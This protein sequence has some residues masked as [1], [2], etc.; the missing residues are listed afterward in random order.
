MLMHLGSDIELTVAYA[1]AAVQNTCSTD[2]ETVATMRDQGQA[3]PTTSAAFATIAF[4]RRYQFQFLFA[5]CCLAGLLDLLQ[6]FTSSA[7]HPLV[8]QY[9]SGC[10]TNVKH[11]LQT[12]TV[13]VQADEIL[14]LTRRE[15]EEEEVLDSLYSP[16]P[17]YN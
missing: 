7:A 11:T 13:R 5:P 4:W 9:A 1:L 10:L 3:A 16:R 14:A 12:E 6:D 8:Q 17:Q 15:N 2:P